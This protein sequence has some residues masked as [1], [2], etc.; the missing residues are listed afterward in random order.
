MTELLADTLSNH[1]GRQLLHWVVQQSDIWYLANR[2]ADFV[3]KIHEPLERGVSVLD[4]ILTLDEDEAEFYGWMPLNDIQIRNRNG[5]QQIIVDRD[6]ND[7]YDPDGE[8][9]HFLNL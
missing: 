9:I 1:L 3:N 5:N 2:C 4:N 6:I 8:L 7:E